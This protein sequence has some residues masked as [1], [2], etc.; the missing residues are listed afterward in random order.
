MTGIL[1]VSSAPSAL[2]TTDEVKAQTRITASSEDTLLGTYI[3]AA[4]EAIDGPLAMAGRAFGSQSWLYIIPA[5]PSRFLIPV[6][7]ATAVSSISYQD[8]DDATQAMTVANY[9]RVIVRDD[10][11]W[12]ELKD[13]VN[14][15]ETYGRSDAVTITVAAGG[16][17]PTKIKQAALLTVAAWYEDRTMG[18]IPSAAQ[19]LID[20]ERIGWIA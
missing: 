1:R 6:P 8:A 17:V 18:D 4:T 9:Y 13:G 11:L 19:H 7:G 16:T 3:A 20:L 14:A 15:P 5:F 10:G 12:L 2:V